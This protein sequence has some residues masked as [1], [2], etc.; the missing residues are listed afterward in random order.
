[1]T[2]LPVPAPSAGEAA[3]APSPRH[4]AASERIPARRIVLP[5]LAILYMAATQ[6]YGLST[7]R[8]ILLPLSVVVLGAILLSSL[9]DPT[10]ILLALAAYVPFSRVYPGNFGGAITALNL[11]NVLTGI[12]ILAWLKGARERG[13]TPVPRAPLNLP[14]VLFALLTIVAFLRGGMEMGNWYWEGAISNL[15]RWLDPF[16][17]Y[18]IFLGS[19]RRKETMLNLVIV[20]LK[21]VLAAALM[22]FVEHADRLDKYPHGSDQQRIRGISEQANQVGSFYV[23][24]GALFAG[25]A[26]V[27]PRVRRYAYLLVPFLLVVR[28]AQYTGSRGTLLGMATAGLAILFVRSKPLCLGVMCLMAVVVANPS[29]LPEGTQRM[30]GRT[31][32][33]ERETIEE[34]LDKSAA[35]RLMAWDAALRIIRDEPLFGV[36]YGLFPVVSTNYNPE[37]K[38]MDAHNTYLLLAAEMGLP[39]LFTFLWILGLVSSETLRLYRGAPDRFLRGVALGFAG[40]LA[41]L[42]VVCMFGS[43]ITSFE[44]FAYFWI[45]AALVVRANALE[46]AAGPAPARAPA[47]A[48]APWIGGVP[49]RP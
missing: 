48:V 19:I 6:T 16:F 11:T 44:I 42:V 37:L 4:G 49:I 29:L 13:A 22:G 43:R 14:V 47:R 3:P 40:G 23:Y 12:G 7:P 9:R 34:S 33:N 28:A 21:A 5:A 15:K 31:F 27:R 10:V 35:R 17:L 30:L 32:A 36:G 24:Y 18:F 46:P 39:A 41:G 1:M 45:L 38:G 8:E 20:L 25:L 2:A 26:L